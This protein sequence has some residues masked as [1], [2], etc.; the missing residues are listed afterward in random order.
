MKWSDEV[1]FNRVFSIELIRYFILIIA[2]VVIG[3]MS[4]S[5]QPWATKTLNSFWLQCFILFLTLLITVYNLETKITYKSLCMSLIISIITAII[6][7]FL[8]LNTTSTDPKL[9]QT[10]LLDKIRHLEKQLDD[11]NKAN[12][13]DSSDTVYKRIQRFQH[14]L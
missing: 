4:T 7:Y 11:K 6:L 1:F 10:I 9:N 14:T 3:N 12:A 8:V 13:F 2:I 5:I